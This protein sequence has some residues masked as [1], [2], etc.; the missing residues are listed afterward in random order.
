MQGRADQT[1]ANV[2]IRGYRPADWERV[3]QI[4]D[5][6]RV[7]ELA[8]GGVD[9]RAFRPMVFAADVDEFFTSETA[10]ACVPSPNGTSTVAGFVSWSGNY[11]TWLYVDPAFQRRGVGRHLLQHALQRIGPEAFTR[12]GHDAAARLFLDLILAAEL[13]EW[14]TAAAYGQL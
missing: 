5:V 4:H 6:A 2:T 9:P 12:G 1:E 11:M 14:L 8:S 10:V 3:C 13:P 7:Q